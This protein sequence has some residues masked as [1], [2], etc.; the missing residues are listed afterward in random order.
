[1]KHL[2]DLQANPG[3]VFSTQDDE[4]VVDFFCGGS[5]VGTVLEC[6]LNAQ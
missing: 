5:G 2:F 3:L 1:M 6:V 4:I